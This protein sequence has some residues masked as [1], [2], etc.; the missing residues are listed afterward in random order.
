MRAA[1]S[2]YYAHNQER[3]TE[4]W[5]YDKENGQCRGNPA[6]SHEV[7]RYMLSLQKRKVSETLYIFR[8]LRH[9]KLRN[10]VFQAYIY[11]LKMEMSLKAHDLLLLHFLK[12][13]MR[14][15]MNS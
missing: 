8:N 3:G 9:R 2:Y 6:L 13:C 14:K 12:D 5:Y 15:I 4:K 7:S 1:V 10:V 11:R